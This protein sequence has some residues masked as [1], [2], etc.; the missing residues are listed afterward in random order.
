VKVANLSSK[1][2]DALLN[3]FETHIYF[4]IITSGG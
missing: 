2:K 4:I 3:N 1:T